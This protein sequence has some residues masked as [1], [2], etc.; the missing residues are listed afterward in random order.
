MTEDQSDMMGDI[1][2]APRRNRGS[3]R[4][5]PRETTEGQHGPAVYQ[6]RDGERLTRTRKSGIDPFEVPA[7]FE[8]PGWKYQ[9]CAVASLGNKEIVRTM[10]IEFHQNGWRPVPASRHDGHFMPR[11][12]AGPIIV[13]DQMLMERPEAMC[14]EAAAED[15]RNAIQQ[16]RDRDEALMGSKANL[17]GAMRDGFEMNSGRYRGT[18]GKLRMSVD[19]ALD[20]PPPSHTL[21]EPGE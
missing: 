7:G 2:A 4:T 13:R 5:T 3:R 10:A 21:A 8:P 6:G 18:G 17:K 1:G 12:E 14:R 19:P 11:G 20:I 16:M 9:W 15:Q